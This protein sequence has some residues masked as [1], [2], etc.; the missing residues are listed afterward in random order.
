MSNTLV[1]RKV[2]IKPNSHDLSEW[3][4]EEGTIVN[5]CSNKHEYPITVAFEDGVGVVVAPDEV[6][7][8]N[9]RP[10]VLS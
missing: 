7:Y 1:G 9:N 6:Q 3:S 8:L 5:V 10:V 2:I 4:G